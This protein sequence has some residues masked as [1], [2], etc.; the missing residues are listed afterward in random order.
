MLRRSA[1]GNGFI[2]EV[3]RRLIRKAFQTADAARIVAPIAA[4]NERSRRAAE[5]MGLEF[6]GIL[7]SL[8]QYRGRRFDIA[9]YTI[10]REESPR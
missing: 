8:V 3:G 2:P 1:W 10:V 5:K 6:E 4:E 9:I 7:R